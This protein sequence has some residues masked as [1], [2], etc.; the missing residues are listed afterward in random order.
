MWERG[1]RTCF[2]D[3][4]GGK[5]IVEEWQQS[6]SPFSFSK[7]KLEVTYRQSE[8]QKKSELALENVCHP[9]GKR[10]L[11]MPKKRKDQWRFSMPLEKDI[12]MK[13]FHPFI[14][15]VFFSFPLATFPSDPFYVT[16]SH[17]FPYVFETVDILFLI[18]DFSTNPVVISIPTLLM[19]SN[20]KWPR[21][22]NIHLREFLK[23]KNTS[24]SWKGQSVLFSYSLW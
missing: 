19:L 1:R 2:R 7:V 15:N 21:C 8:A 3:N 11:R 10:C 22:W 9:L 17:T 16:T 24:P 23:V 5:G 18:R 14:L 12:P 4:I 20:L 13:Q 6:S